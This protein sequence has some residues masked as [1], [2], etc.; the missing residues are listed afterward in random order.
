MKKVL[1]LAVLIVIVV[2]QFKLHASETISYQY[3]H[4]SK[5]NVVSKNIFIELNTTGVN[6]NG[7][8]KLLYEDPTDVGEIIIYPNPTSC[9]VSI[10]FK[11][12]EWNQNYNR[13]EVWSL[14][15]YSMQ[16]VLLKT[17]KCQG[18]RG[19]MIVSSFPAGMYILLIERSGL[20]RSYT[21]IKK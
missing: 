18:H 20:K 8:Q 4:N 13:D 14:S 10:Q 3:S 15:L 6:T 9:N 11:G 1:Y 17:E 12:P 16:G 21:L 19:E 2:S 5:G 7:D